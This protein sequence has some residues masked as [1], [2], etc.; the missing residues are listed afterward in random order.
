[1]I[2]TVASNKHMIINVTKAIIFTGY[3]SICN[4]NSI[5]CI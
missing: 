1:M 5:C 3:F 4:W 2:E